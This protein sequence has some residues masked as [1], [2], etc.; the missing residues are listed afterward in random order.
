M[1]CIFGITFLIF[2]NLAGN[3][4]QLGI[5]MQTAIDPTA[6]EDSLRKGPVIAWAIGSLTASALV[7]IATR[8][9]SI[10][11]NNMFGVLKIALVFI[12]AFLGIIYGSIQ[13][14]GCRSIVWQNKGEGGQLGDI[15]LALFYAMYPYSGYEQPFYVLAEVEKPKRKFAKSTL[16]SM[17]TILILYPLINVS[18]LCMN[19]Y[20]GPE[21]LRSVNAATRFF[22][23]LSGAADSG[24]GLVGEKELGVVRGI[25]I[26]LALFIFGNLLAQTYTASRVKQEIAKEGILPWSLF[27]AAGNDTLFARW[28]SSSP[29]SSRN[30][31]QPN[32]D[33][34]RE[35][36]PIAATF[37]HWVF[38][39]IL[40]LVVGFSVPKLTQA[41]NLLTYLYSFII[42][43]I[44]GLLTVG[45][46]LY[47]K[48]D[49]W[50]HRWRSSPMHGRGGGRRWDE[51]AE[52]KPWL[53]PLPTVVAT[54]AL[55]FLLFGAFVP[56]SG[57]GTDDL[58]SWIRPTVGWGVM[59]LP[60][61]WWLG[62]EAAQWKGRWRL[63]R[64]R[65]TY[66]EADD[67][68]DPVQKAELVIVEKRS[69]ASATFDTLSWT[70]ST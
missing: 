9:F 69:A 41:Y 7:N 54:V 8:K 12:M 1:T 45:G 67:D 52:W 22:W 61:L 63:V 42:L 46:L 28:W 32:P 5:Y 3:A 38:E 4:L 39:V 23:K 20:E 19:P 44:L 65:V 64:K 24:S 18:Y 62:L 26:V 33:N 68:N 29:G 48:L 13:G 70:D 53:D 31:Y 49:A 66:V 35:Q 59:I 50:L 27:F 40:V 15:V 2:G 58:A 36:A 56:T 25:H 43:G 55:T 47:L 16:Y 6:T 17:L 30:P 21:E 10:W 37:L 34:H 60:F 51:K 11:L 14:G 57:S